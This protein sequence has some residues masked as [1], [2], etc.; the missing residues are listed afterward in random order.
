MIVKRNGETALKREIR[1]Q[2]ARSLTARAAQGR[3][4]T[5]AGIACYQS[6][7]W[8]SATFEGHRHQFVVRFDGGQS[9]VEPAAMRFREKICGDSVRLP[10]ELLADLVL[11]GE[12]SVVGPC[13]DVALRLHFE[14][15]TVRD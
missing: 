6:E 12:D 3:D 5:T 2:L 7:R 1:R 11:V 13:G 15:L 9:Q 14:A 10:G 4:D 8:A